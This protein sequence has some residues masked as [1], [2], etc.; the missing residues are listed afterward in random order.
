[1]TR[2]LGSIGV[3]SNDIGP[4]LGLIFGRVAG[5]DMYYTRYSSPMLNSIEMWNSN[6]LRRFLLDPKR[7][8]PGNKCGMEPVKDEAVAV[9]LIQFLKELTLANYS[10][11][12]SMVVNYYN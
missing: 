4:P 11:I 10:F 7:L 6:H 5:S 12:R 3:D 9:D 8:I 2:D 1:M